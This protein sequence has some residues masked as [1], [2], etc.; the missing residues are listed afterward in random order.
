MET[1][2]KKD[3]DLRELELTVNGEKVELYIQKP[4]YED[5][6]GAQMQKA[7]TLQEGL[8]NNLYLKKEMDNILRSRGVWDDELQARLD[9]MHIELR[10]K[11]AK[12]D[13]G[14]MKLSEARQ[15]AIEISDLRNSIVLISSARRDF[16]ELTAD[17]RAEQAELDY[18]VASC[19]VYN[20]DRKRKYFKDYQD[21]LSRKSDEDAYTIAQRFAEIM[22]DQIF[23]EKRLPETQFLMEYGFVN[24]DLRF[25]DADGKLVDSEGNRINEQGQ[26]V[27]VE[28]GEEIV[29]DEKVRKPFLDENGEPVAA[30]KKE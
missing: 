4:R 2:E 9:E 25:I 17:G 10:E 6:N 28:N 20:S 8:K 21:Y 15:L 14:D 18:L 12:L 5:I 7:L 3:L 29:I 19:T 30:K 1:T 24:E 22:Y 26:K 13:G 16:A 27:K 23:D 11:L